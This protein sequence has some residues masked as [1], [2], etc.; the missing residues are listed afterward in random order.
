MAETCRY[1]HAVLRKRVRTDVL[2]LRKRVSTD[3][4]LE[5]R[6]P[7]STDTSVTIDRQLQYINISYS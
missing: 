3:V 4:V 1:R 7:V 2:E 5:L 6:K